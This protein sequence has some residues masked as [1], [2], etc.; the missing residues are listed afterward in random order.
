MK[1]SFPFC[2]ILLYTCFFS[3]CISV[4]KTNK[5]K[6]VWADEFEY[7]GHP[8]PSYW[9]YDE[10][11][12][13]WGNNELQFYTSENL[14][15]ARVENGTLII[16]AQSN[17]NKPK[18]YTSARLVTKGKA[19]WKYGYIES[20]ITRRQRYLACNMDAPRRKSLWRLAQQW[21]NRHHGACGV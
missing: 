21:G 9:S 3:G 16:E 1:A 8:N 15:N 18:G 5:A 6:L 11:D 20:K 13:G 19:A 2:F 7:E 12:G 4:K 17:P 14:N 10:G